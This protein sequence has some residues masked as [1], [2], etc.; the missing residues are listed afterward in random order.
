M[1][2]AERELNSDM[3]CNQFAWLFVPSGPRGPVA[4]AGTDEKVIAPV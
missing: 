2:S 3:A 1:H 4:G